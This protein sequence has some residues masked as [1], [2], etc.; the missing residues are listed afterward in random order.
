MRDGAEHVEA[1]GIALSEQALAE[2]PIVIWVVD[3]SSPLEPGD[4]AMASRLAGKRVIA[5]LNKSDL[6][7]RLE[8]AGLEARLSASGATWWQ[9]VQVSAAS[10]AGLATL[11][12]ALLVALG[13]GPAAP[14]G[15]AVSN[16]RH[17]DALARGRAALERARARSREGAPGEIVAIELR[18]G[19][20]AIAE[21]TGEG[22]DA[23]LL[24]RIFGR[25][26][27]GK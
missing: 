21:V 4:R 16:A 7:A 9:C 27:I 26:C 2:S 13:G 24:D 10:G 25:F 6:P 8:G 11:R 15:L 5:V 19:L 22:V 17:V 1:L 14:L 12:A 18:D 3:A 20:S 23:D